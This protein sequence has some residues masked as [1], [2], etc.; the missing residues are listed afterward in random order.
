[1]IKTNL[2]L[3]NVHAPSRSHER[4]SRSLSTTFH[5]ANVEK[6]DDFIDWYAAFARLPHSLDLT[7]F[8]GSE[9]RCWPNGVSMLMM[10]TVWQWRSPFETT[11]NLTRPE[12]ARYVIRMTMKL[13]D[14]LGIPLGEVTRNG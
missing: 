1:L 13:A 11:K 5:G 8:G 14:L 10:M 7:R 6:N 3:E 2:A 9:R 12:V 4:G